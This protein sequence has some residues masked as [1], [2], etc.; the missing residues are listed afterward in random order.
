MFRLPSRPAAFV[1]SEFAG[2]LYLMNLALYLELYGD[3]T[4]PA[5]PGLAL[6]PG[7]FL[8]LAGE[9]ICGPA[10]LDDPIWA[11]LAALSGRGEDEPPGL[12]F[13]APDGD[14]VER[15]LDHLVPAMDVRVALALGVQPGTALLFLCR[16]PG[17]VALSPTRLEATFQLATHPLTIRIAG[18]DRDP[19]WVPAAGRAIEFRYE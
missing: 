9:R 4:Q 13:V 17:R 19:G 1:A 11:L 3:F 6:H 15:W 7:D 16:R 5:R 12:G 10:L 8:A 14:T 18:L 2:V